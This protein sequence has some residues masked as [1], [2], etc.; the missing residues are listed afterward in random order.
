MPWVPF[1]AIR[2]A[3]VQQESSGNVNARAVASGGRV[4][5]G[6]LQL[7]E[8]LFRDH[9]RPGE[10][11]DRQADV[12][13]VAERAFR[14]AYDKRK[15][16]AGQLAVEWFSGPG[17][18]SE[19]P[20]VPW[21]RNKSDGHK[22]VADYVGDILDRLNPIGQAEAAEPSRA[23]KAAWSPPEVGSWAPPEASSAW[24]PP[25]ASASWVP[26][27]AQVDYPELQSQ[28]RPELLIEPSEADAASTD[29]WQRPAPAAG[30]PRP[31]FAEAWHSSMS[32]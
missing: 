12:E 23:S 30:A 31:S 25:E 1:E 17:N 28:V 32:R 29:T 13:A 8:A 6:T 4:H 18:V 9:A 15:G 26:L 7:G 2:A 21:R 16:D 27:E 22:S 3:F 10:R 11:F 24:S 19:G 14:Q 5:K 20:G